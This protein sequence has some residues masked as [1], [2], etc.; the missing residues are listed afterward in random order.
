VPTQVDFAELPEGV[1]LQ[2]AESGDASGV[3]VLLLHGLADSWRAFEPVLQH[4]PGSLRVFALSQRGH[5]DSSR[6]ETG[7]GLD[8]FAMDIVAFHDALGLDAVVVVGHSLGSSVAQRFALDYPRRTLGLVL[9][10][11]PL[12][13]A[14]NPL[15]RELWDTVVSVL[16]DPVDPAFVCAREPAGG[17]AL[18]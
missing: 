18:N 11:S 3:P 9:I 8:D 16:E 12:H 1:R 7:Y 10:G 2:Y 14:G 17:A 13:L 15:L 5:G 4:L 6:P